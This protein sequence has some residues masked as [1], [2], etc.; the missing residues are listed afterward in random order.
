MRTLSKLDACQLSEVANDIVSLPLW[1][2]DHLHKWNEALMVKNHNVPDPEHRELAEIFPC[3]HAT[4]TQ[5]GFNGIR[6][7]VALRIGHNNVHSNGV[8]AQYPDNNGNRTFMKHL[9]NYGNDQTFWPAWFSSPARCR[10]VFIAAL[11][12]YIIPVSRSQPSRGVYEN[13][14]WVVIKPPDANRKG[15]YFQSQTNRS[16]CPLLLWDVPKVSAVPIG[17]PGDPPT[18]YQLTGFDHRARPDK[19]PRKAHYAR[20]ADIIQGAPAAQARPIN[21]SGLPVYD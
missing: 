3:V 12:H 13:V 19:D 17:S 14:T 6:R 21:N 8:Y 11:K 9:G 4:R 2:E 10:F 16:A 7:E 15:K 20:T 5:A 1:T 18:W